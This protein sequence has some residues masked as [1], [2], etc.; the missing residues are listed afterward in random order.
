MS[1]YTENPELDA[2]AYDDEADAWAE[3]C[4]KAAI[5]APGIVLKQL[6]SIKKPGDWD[7]KK[8]FAGCHSADEILHWAIGKCCD[9]VSDR[10]AEFMVEATPESRD[11][12]LQA[13]A[14]WF[15]GIYSAEIYQEWLEDQ[16]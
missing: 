5:E 1:R 15:A 8:D 10:Y 3:H 2:A 7:G 12:M 6:R 14:D 13:M 4:E 11:R 16:Q 9:D